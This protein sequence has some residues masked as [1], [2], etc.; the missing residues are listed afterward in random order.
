MQT[1]LTFLYELL[2]IF[3]GSDVNRDVRQN[4]FLF[5]FHG[6]DPLMLI[7]GLKICIPGSPCPTKQGEGGIA[8]DVCRV[9]SR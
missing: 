3:P 4:D 1:L 5:S 2:T 6:S 9:S 8:E 7:L